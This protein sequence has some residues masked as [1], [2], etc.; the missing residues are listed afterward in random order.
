MAARALCRV[1][2]RRSWCS[3][4]A[5]SEPRSCIRSWHT[6]GS[7]SMP[8]TPTGR[9]HRYVAQA[10]Q[11]FSEGCIS[12]GCP[13]S[14]F[15]FLI[16]PLASRVRASSRSHPPLCDCPVVSFGRGTV[17]DLAA[18][19]NFPQSRQGSIVFLSLLTQ[20]ERRRQSAPD[21]YRK[22]LC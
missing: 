6:T 18:S 21:S 5:R 7:R 8:Y 1:S 15:R 4:R 16:I 19:Y 13:C 22:P 17:V 2:I 3:S 14:V 12:C 9:R 20:Q 11:R 10:A